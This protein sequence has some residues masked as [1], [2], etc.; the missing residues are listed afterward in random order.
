MVSL[1]SLVYCNTSNMIKKSL[2][3]I[4]LQDI[5]QHAE[6]RPYPNWPLRR[7]VVMHEIYSN[8]I[9]E[10]MKILVMVKWTKPFL[11]LLNSKWLSFFCSSYMCT[12]SIVNINMYSHVTGNNF[13]VTLVNGKYCH[14]IIILIYYKV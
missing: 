5:L 12:S 6:F 4:Y 7:H 3:F 13:D 1:F 8:M 11:F 14:D 10:L 9:I 2:D